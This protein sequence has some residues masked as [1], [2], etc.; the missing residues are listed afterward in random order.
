M[1]VSRRGNARKF[2]VV[3]C[4]W[5]RQLSS[6][7][8]SFKVEH[9]H[10]CASNLCFAWEPFY[11]LVDWAWRTNRTTSTKSPSQFMW[12]LVVLLSRRGSVSKPEH[13]INWT[14]HIRDFRRCYSWL[15]TEKCRVC[16][17]E[18]TEMYA[19]K[20]GPILKC[21]PKWYRIIHHH[22]VVCLTSGPKPLTKPA[23]HIV[24]SRAS[25]FM[26]QYPLLS[27]RSSSSFLRLLPRLPVTSIPLLHFLQ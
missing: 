18:F 6:K 20:L 22:L 21:N 19:K 12:F 27:L 24:R 9:H 8:T 4:I 1:V 3:H 5:A 10:I 26:W 17:V 13:L 25:S 7:C 2:R 23:L 15:L 11:C 16:V 14:Q